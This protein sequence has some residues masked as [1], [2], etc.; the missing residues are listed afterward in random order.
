[1][2]FL[3]SIF[4]YERDTKTPPNNFNRGDCLSL[5][6]RRSKESAAFARTTPQQKRPWSKRTTQRRK[7]RFIPNNLTAERGSNH[8]LRSTITGNF[9]NPMPFWWV[10]GVDK[11]ITSLSKDW[12]RFSNLVV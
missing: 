6:S 7:R 8:A 3:G 12:H 9:C 2:I 5:F 11:P 4:R 1:M 10:P